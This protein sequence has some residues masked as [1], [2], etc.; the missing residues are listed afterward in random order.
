[1]HKNGQNRQIVLHTATKPTENRQIKAKPGF[2]DAY[3]NVNSELNV[4]FN[5]QK[6]LQKGF[7]IPK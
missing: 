2:D 6:N 5:L 7:F 1:M 3:I 4:K